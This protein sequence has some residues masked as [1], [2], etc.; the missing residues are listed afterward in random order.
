MKMGLRILGIALLGVILTGCGGGGSGSGSKSSSATSTTTTTTTSTTTYYGTFQ[1]STVVGVHYKTQLGTV[2]KEGETDAQG[3]FEYLSDGATIAPV[4]F[5]VGGVVLGTLTPITTGSYSMSVFDLVNASDGEARVKA[6]NLQRFLASVDTSPNADIIWVSAATRT[7]LASES[8]KLNELTGSDF[9]AR[10]TTLINTLV[11]NGT[12]SA[13]TTLV[14]ESEVTSHIQETKTR[15]DAARVGSV[16]LITGAES[17]PADGKSRLL[18]QV[19]A[20]TSDSKALSGGLVTVTTTLGSL[21]GETDL[22]ASATTPTTR[23]ERMTDA[24]GTVTL[25]LTPGCQSGTGTV[26]ASIGGMLASATVT[27]TSTTV[28]DNATR[29]TGVFQGYTLVGVHYKSQLGGT[30]LEGETD[31]E[32]KFQYLV[33]GSTV[34][35][36]TFSIGGVTLGT[37][38]LPNYSGYYAV[39]VNDLVPADGVD[40]LDKAIGIQRFLSSISTSATPTAILIKASARS[41]LASA[42]INLAEL[43]VAQFIPSATTLINTLIAANA[44]P[45]GSALLETSAVVEN[46]RIYKRQVDLTRIVSL[47][48]MTGTGGV[49][50]DGA[51]KV[52]IQIKAKAQSDDSITG[53]L[54]RIE[55]SGG[56]LDTEGNLCSG[57]VTP[58]RLVDKLIQADGFAYVTL[59]PGCQ[60]GSVQVTATAGGVNVAKTVQFLPGPLSYVHSSLVANPSTLSADG[61]STSQI[62]VMLKDGYG[63]PLVDGTTVTLATDLGTI[64]GGASKTILSGQATFTLVAPGSAGVAHLSI[65][66]APYLTASVTISATPTA[67]LPT[68]PGVFQGSIVQGLHYKAELNGVIQEGETDSEGKFQFFT[69]GSVL[70]PVTFSVGGVVLGTMTPASTIGIQTINVHDLVNPS[71]SDAVQKAINLQRFLATLDTDASSDSIVISA[72]ERS[73]LVTQSVTL[74][75]LPVAG[76]DASAQGLIDV[77]IAASVKPSGTILASAASVIDSLR[78][79]K[80]RIDAARVGDM[81]ID[82]G[83]DAVRADG[84]SHILVRVTAKTPG[85][86]PLMGGLLRLSTTEG[87]LGSETNL[88]GATATVTSA[89]D[90]LTDATG[91]VNLFLTPRCVSATTL[92]TATL[93]GKIVTKTIQFT[94]GAATTTNSS[95]TVNPSTLPADG[96][97]TATVTVSLRDV[98]DNPVADGTRVT[99]LTTAGAIQGANTATTVSGRAGFTLVAASTNTDAVLTLNE[100]SGLSNTVRIGLSGGVSGSSGRKASSIQMTAGAQKIFVRGVGKSETVG[101]AIQVRDAVGDPL[102]ESSLG[103]NYPVHV[104]NLRV[105]LKTRPQ[106]GETVAGIGRKTGATLESDEETHKST[107]SVNAILIRSRGGSAN[108]TLTSGVRPGVVEFLVEALDTDGATVLASAVSSLVAISSGPAHAMAISEA[109]KDGAVNLKDYGRGGVYCRQ[110]SALVTDRYGNAVP[111]GTVISLNLIDAVLAQSATG[112]ISA[113]S[114]NLTDAAASFNTSRLI[115]SSGIGRTIQ[116]GDQVLFDRIDSA[117]DRR[118]F[119]TSPLSATVLTTHQNFSQ[120]LSGLSYTVGASLRGGAIHGYSGQTGCDPALLTTGVT[121]TTGGVA[122]IRVTYPAN[123]ETIQLGCL[124]YNALTGLYNTTTVEDARFPNRSGQVL[125]VAGVNEVNDVGASGVTLVTR[126]KFCY[127]PLLPANVTVSPTRIGGNTSQYFTVTTEDDGSIQVPNASIS[128]ASASNSTGTVTITLQSVTFD[129]FGTPT[130]G[131]A[132]PS[133]S[134]LT[135]AY[136]VAT[137]Y[138]VVTGT[139]RSDD[140]GGIYCSGMNTNVSI[141]VY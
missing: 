51:S 37:M 62:T 14:P 113:S 65:L 74:S 61:K 81:S 70:S 132:G 130:F 4:T 105:T 95:I 13:G 76:F 50:A 12:L 35:P 117:Q 60:S 123:R 43:P 25:L 85:N 100:F 46:L 68:Y 58:V 49:V 86:N 23:V 40:A 17:V 104:N 134:T 103:L 73:A 69:I 124:G 78:E 115:D 48:I 18:I 64:S 66:E 20:K 121:S 67:S 45:A 128:C 8:V 57:S 109:F 39:T 87:T 31:S 54:V 47:E 1:G 44:L 75:A 102:D 108:V 24:S 10:A 118:R 5:S 28:P 33:E 91:T 42:S 107:D 16:T 88:C 36:V 82:L 138:A 52:G 137:F 141:S 71:D 111:D 131:T 63:N 98:N 89:V 38:T 110:G 136:G 30:V 27:F 119:V 32:G 29:R 140:A 22:C 56:S 9:D 34:A 55:T 90:R 94:P 72:A 83:A 114:P 79:T 125:I 96:K 133:S 21:G 135:N 11:S 116:T 120:T 99:L 19:R 41:A 80:I 139:G 93:G 59:T 2:I 106:G 126:G 7:A 122:P 112:A 77:L 84:S 92:L 6:T 97:A 15:I 53:A 129:A 26:T 3:R 101:V 127:S